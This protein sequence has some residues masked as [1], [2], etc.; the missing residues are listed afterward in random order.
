[1]APITEQAPETT[2]TREVLI[3]AQTEEGFSV[4]SSTSPQ[5]MFLVQGDRQHPHCSCPAFK[6]LGH[7]AGFRCDHIRAVE[8]LLPELPLEQT[9]EAETPTQP[10]VAERGNG[11][12]V[13]MTLKRSIS[14]DRRIDSMSIEFAMPLGGSTQDAVITKAMRLLETQEM[15]SNSFLDQRSE[16]L[17]QGDEQPDEESDHSDGTPARILGINGMNTRYG[18]RLYL[19]VQVNGQKVKV[20]GNRQKIGEYLKEA[21]CGDLGGN[22][23]SGVQINQPCR[24]ITRRSEDGQYLNVEQLL[25][26]RNG[27]G[28]GRQGR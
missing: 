7:Q 3:A 12:P 19:A 1:M 2:A 4:Y 22:I 14:P 24:A 27:N 16:E 9:G 20:F 28:N 23:R 17:E 26:A 21:G 15:I 11:T 13:T 10:A 8:N 18:W 25:P 5:V 6:T